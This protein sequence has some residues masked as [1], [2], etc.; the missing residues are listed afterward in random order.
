[1]VTRR[2][3]ALLMLLL[4]AYAAFAPQ[5][6]A[7]GGRKV[8]ESMDSGVILIYVCIVAYMCNVGYVTLAPS[9]T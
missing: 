9:R 1:M 6:Q 3:S 4:P 2:Q 8:L 7:Y 5:A